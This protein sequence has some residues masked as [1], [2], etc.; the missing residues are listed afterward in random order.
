MFV[1][2][3]Y[4][5]LKPLRLESLVYITDYTY[6]E[7]EVIAME[8]MMLEVLNFD[9]NVPSSYSFLRRYCHVTR[10]STKLFRMAQFLLELAL[11]ETEMLKYAPSL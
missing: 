10:A 3:K 11:L 1:A 7:E 4:E 5:D 8:K 6:R 2:S 9:L